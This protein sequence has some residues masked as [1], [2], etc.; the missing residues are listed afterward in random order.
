MDQG[1]IF[2]GIILIAFYLFSPGNGLAFANHFFHD[3][4]LPV[5]E[6]SCF[7]EADKKSR[8]N[9]LSEDGAEGDI[10]DHGCN[11][12]S[13]I[14]SVALT[15]QSAHDLASLLQG[16]ALQ[17]YPNVYIPIFVPPQNLV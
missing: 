1:K 17:L 14:P 9:P 2:L 8:D 7:T 4:G 10:F 15:P 6:C 11:C 12:S 5:I 16:G 13:H 3:R